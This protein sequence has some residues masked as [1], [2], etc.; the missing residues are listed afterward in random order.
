MFQIVAAIAWRQHGAF[1]T[2]QAEAAGVSR[3]WLSRAAAGGTIE[4]RAPGVYVIAGT[5]RT[6]R[7]TLMVDVLRAGAG[8]LVTAEAGL[9]LWC[10]ELELP[11]R[12]TIATTRTCGVVGSATAT[13]VRSTDLDLANPGVVD[14]IPVAGVARCL[15]D[16]ASER[17]PDA[18]IA[19]INACERHLP[20]SFGALVDVLHTHARSGRPGIASFRAAL[21]QLT[22][23]V[24]DSEFERFV[25]R[26]LSAAGVATPTHHH[27]IRIPGEAAI[28]LDIG[29]VPERVDLELDGRDHVTRK[30]TARRDRQRDRLLIAHDWA[31]PR[32]VWDDYLDDPIGL[33]S[34]VADL[35][36]SRR[37]RLRTS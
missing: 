35:V 24:P 37:R 21:A 31:V 15:L 10:P 2:A 30:R 16:V 18:V 3:S 8:T 9:A 29:W 12:A 4:R 5:P 6:A 11:R 28:E 25:L 17:D 19:L 14:G 36:T 20:L 32:Y 34:Y 23:S 26:D 33:V 22:R 1:S 13:Y 7:Q 27:V